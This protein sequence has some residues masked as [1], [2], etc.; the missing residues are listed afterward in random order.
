MTITPK[1]NSEIFLAIDMFTGYVQLKPL[2]SRETHELIEAVKS[3]IILPFGIPKFFRC[4]NESAMT[5]STEFHNFMEPLGVQFLPWSTE[6]P[7]SNGAAERAVQT[8]KNTIR[9]FSQQENV[10]D[11]C[12][13]FWH[14]FV[15]AH[16][17]LTFIY[18]FSPE[19]LHFGFSNPAITDLIEI[20]P[21]IFNQQDYAKQIFPKLRKQ[22]KQQEKKPNPWTK[23]T[24][25][26]EIRR[27]KTKSS[28]QDKLYSIVSYK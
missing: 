13:D 21:K 28:Y 27:D 16:N 20:W 11:K 15:S 12:V 14:F 1:G 17:K 4:D 18:G 22:E 7:W 24:S 9:T 6:S 19:Q 10:E 26:I 23:P 3:T 2:K 5:N 25:P 8:I